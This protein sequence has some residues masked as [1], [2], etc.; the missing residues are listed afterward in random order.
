VQIVSHVLGCNLRKFSKQLSMSS[1][2]G[3][4]ERNQ[5]YGMKNG[6]TTMSARF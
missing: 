2:L 6:R 1:F 3:W 4:R 5:I